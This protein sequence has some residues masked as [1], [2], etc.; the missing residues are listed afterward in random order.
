[1]KSTG[2]SMGIGKQF[3][4]AFAYGYLGS[5]SKSELPMKGMVFISVRDEDKGQVIAIAQ[6][7]I[8]LGFEI[9][10]TRG[11]AQALQEA[12]I[13]CKPVNKY[14]EGRPHIIDS[15]KNDEIDFIINTTEGQKSIAD[16]YTIRRSALQ[17]RVCYTTTLAGAKALILAMNYQHD[18]EVCALQVLHAMY[19]KEVKEYE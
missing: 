18:I 2:E 9:C 15:I 4:Q 17:H 11:T 3:G 1:M 13:E 6:R 14:R 10:A 8:E 12:D 7:L 5:Q 16:S 19:M